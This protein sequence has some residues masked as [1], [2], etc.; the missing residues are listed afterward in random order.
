LKQIN[1]GAPDGAALPFFAGMGT[2]GLSLLPHHPDKEAL[3]NGPGRP[4]D[5]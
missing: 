4:L 2:T 3:F 1:N 5:E